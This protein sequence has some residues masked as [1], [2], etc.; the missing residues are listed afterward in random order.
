MKTGVHIGWARGWR[1]LISAEM[2]FGSISQI[3]GLGWYMYQRRAFMDTAGMYAGII[4]VML[5]GLIV[6]GVASD[7]NE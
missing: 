4:F 6:E 1:G 3:G 2:I 7:L 5:I